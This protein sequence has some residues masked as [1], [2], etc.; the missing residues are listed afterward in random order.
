LSS[1][2]CLSSE[3]VKVQDNGS[4]HVQVQ[5]NVNVNV[6]VSDARAVI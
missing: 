3:R 5:V 6:S 4:V 2:A 1:T